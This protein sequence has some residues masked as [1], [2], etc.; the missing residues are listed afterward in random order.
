VSSPQSLPATPLPQGGAGTT[1]AGF[2]LAA[3]GA[4]LAG[5]GKRAAL[6][7]AIGTTVIGGLGTLSDPNGS[8]TGNAIRAAGEVGGGLAGIPLGAAIGGALAGPPG[9]FAGMALAPLLT[10]SAGK[11]L[12]N[13]FAGQFEGPMYQQRKQDE[14][15][16]ERM[17]ADAAVQ[18]PLMAQAAE[19]QAA[20]ER[21]KAANDA[22]LQMQAATHLGVVNNTL[23]RS[24]N[25]AA[26]DGQLANSIMQGV[27]G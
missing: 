27:F 9:A 12:A 16:R 23:A 4:G 25:Q 11:G 7:V 2:D 17:L 8:A 18:L 26:F 20:M 1:E 3:L 24:N 14:Y 22:Y 6:P 13:I 19:A 15:Q 10:G 21:R 5:F